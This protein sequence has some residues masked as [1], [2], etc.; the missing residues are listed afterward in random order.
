MSN[1]EELIK[2]HLVNSIMEKTKAAILINST[3]DP[4]TGCWN[5]TGA[6]KQG[7]GQ[8]TFLKR[9][10]NAHRI[11]YILF[12]NRY[13]LLVDG[14]SIYACHKCDNKLCVNP[15]HI[16]EGTYYDNLYDAVVKDRMKMPTTW[17]NEHSVKLKEFAEFAKNNY[18]K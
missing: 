18:K 4:A 14:A 1:R 2:Q 9:N 10:L 17:I 8:I 15:E 3:P 6:Q 11:S 12:N 5:W 16:F 13:E 7:Y